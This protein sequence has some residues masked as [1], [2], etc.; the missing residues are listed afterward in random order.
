MGKSPL[1]LAA[2]AADAVPRLGFSRL[3]QLHRLGN[4]LRQELLGND[5]RD[6]EVLYPATPAGKSELA[7]E[8]NVLTLLKGA[9]FDF[10]IPSM[11]GQT[12][13]QQRNPVAVL[14][15]V[16]GEFPQ[17]HKL[18]PGPFTESFAIA[19]AQ[20]H[21]LPTSYFSDAGLPEFDSATILHSRVAE[22]DQMASTGRVPAALLGRWERAMEDVTL[23][24]FHP[25]VIHGSISDA[26]IRVSGG[27]E[28]SRLLGLTDWSGL[29][30]ADP[31]E[32][33]WWIAGGTILETAQ[34][35][36]ARYQAIRQA[37]DVNIL[38]RAMLY[39]ELQ[40]GRWLLYCLQQGAEDEIA[41]AEDGLS[42]LRDEFEA[43]NLLELSASHATRVSTAGAQAI[44]D[45]WLNDSPNT[46]Q[47][48]GIIQEAATVVLAES[49]S[50]VGFTDE[51]KNTRKQ[52]PKRDNAPLD[53]VDLE[54]LF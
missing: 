43:G 39:S 37:A 38:R 44:S 36:T 31:A 52:K 46:G 32:D 41:Q 5:N 35:L 26:A 12:L 19:L 11:L 23:F 49:Q 1:I 20:I 47:N 10:E 9:Q 50:P 42:E 22:L 53:S 2:L 25:T 51:P 45:T 7:A 6:Y 30:I 21:S 48:L 14:S 29:R 27:R 18:V 8:V 24:R 17:P 4:L 34:D 40:L 33:F 28:G 13:D 3:G 16:L 54:E 15:R